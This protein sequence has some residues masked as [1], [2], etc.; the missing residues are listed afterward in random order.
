MKNIHQLRARN[1]LT[2]Q[3]ALTAFK[4]HR[5]PN[6]FELAPTVFRIL[7]DLIILEKPL[8][9]YEADRGWPA[10]SAK[11]ILSVLLYAMEETEGL[12]WT[13]P[14]DRRE[15]LEQDG[16]RDMVDYLTK[17]GS[18]DVLAW[19]KKLDLTPQEARIF[20]ILHD[21]LGRVVQT[22]V[23]V[24]R[25]WGDDAATDARKTVSV[26]ICNIRKK[27]ARKGYRI[28]TS[29]GVGFELVEEPAKVRQRDKAFEAQSREQG[30]TLREITREGG[31]AP[32]TV[33]RAVRRSAAG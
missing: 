10:R 21:H 11:A 1:Q 13:A 29:W 22:E 25:I 20:A 8:E 24:R 3:Q 15:R 26:M 17:T 4:F 6:R 31:A 12:F 27:I 2:E 19:Q 9:A 28:E 23:I 5:T 18:E 33:L 16:A 7:R 32:S 14:E 30:K